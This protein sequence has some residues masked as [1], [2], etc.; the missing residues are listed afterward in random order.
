MNDAFGRPQTVLVVGGGSDI[1]LATLERLV[2]TATRAAIAGRRHESLV[3]AAR[4]A[5]GDNV[6]CRGFHFEATDGATHAQLVAD[7]AA[8]LG[9]IDLAIVAHGDLGQSFDLDVEPAEVAR[10]VAVNH[11]GAASISQ[12]IARQLAHQGHGTLVAMS[13]VAAIRPRLPNLPYASAKAGFDAFALGLDHALADSGAR[14]MV[15]RPGFVH[16]KMTR[17]LDEQPLAVD[18]DTVADAIIDGLAKQRAIVWVPAPLRAAPAF[19][20]L[21]TALWR[22]I[23]DR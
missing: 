6:E 15:V 18:A 22:R 21:P 11:G 2:P 19:R 10:L 20:L 3:D 4:H 23:S 16:T 8:W 5:L 14:V 9:E 7:A 12:A 13:S 1:A 17:G